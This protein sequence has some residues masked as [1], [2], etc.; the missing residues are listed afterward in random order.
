MHIHYMQTICICIVVNE[1]V[2]HL[3]IWT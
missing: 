3:N 1:S 2:L